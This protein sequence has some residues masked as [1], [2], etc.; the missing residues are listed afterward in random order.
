MEI[1]GGLVV[2]AVC[3]G[4]WIAYGNW[5]ESGIGPRHFDTAV[6][7]Q[8]LRELFHDRVARAG[9]KIVD[10]GNP[11][12]AQSSLVT[13]IRQQIALTLSTTAD[14]RT[15]VRVG[16]DRWSTN[17]GIPSKAHTVRLRLNSFVSS[18]QA[19]DP[20]VQVRRAGARG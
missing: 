12:V 1:V 18:V 5:L 11:L 8:A 19:Q 17:Y 15:K 7:P 4:A 20:N 14:G 9:W 16:A 6:S 10:D 2:L 13:G 3:I